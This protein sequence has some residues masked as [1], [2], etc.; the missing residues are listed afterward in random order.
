VALGGLPEIAVIIIGVLLGLPLLLGGLTFYAAHRWNHTHLLLDGERLR[1]E[2]G[3]IPYNGVYRPRQLAVQAVSRFGVEL[4]GS[5]DA[6]AGS[7]SRFYNL[8]AYAGEQ[9]KVVLV[10]HI[11]EGY[12]AFMAQELNAEL[13]T[14]IMPAEDSTTEAE[15][16]AFDLLSQPTEAIQRLR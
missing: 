16:P 6:N 12:A 1:V 9:Q 3:P 5:A 8:V 4:S 10:R 7:A 14:S 13:E 2:S 15:V 11:P